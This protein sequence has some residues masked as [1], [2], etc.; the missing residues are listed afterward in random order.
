MNYEGYNMRKIYSVYLNRIYEDNLHIQDF[1][2]E[3]LAVR[4]IRELNKENKCGYSI[5]YYIILPGALR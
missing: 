5:I 4:F 1:E 2:S 3:S